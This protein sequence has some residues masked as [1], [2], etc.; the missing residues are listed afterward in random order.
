[1]ERRLFRPLYVESWFTADIKLGAL[2]LNL[3]TPKCFAAEC[4][5]C[6]WAVLVAVDGVVTSAVGGHVLC[7]RVRAAALRCDDVVERV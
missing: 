1:M 6:E 3:E 7:P 4:Y 2:A 5:A